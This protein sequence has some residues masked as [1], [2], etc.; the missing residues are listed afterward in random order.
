MTAPLLSVEGLHVR[1][2]IGAGMFAKGRTLRAVSDVS[3]TM[4][5]GECLGIVGESGCGKS[6]LARAI[7]GFV[8]PAQGRVLWRGR[9]V[10]ELDAAGLREFRR[11]V[12]PVFQ[13]PLGSLNPRMTVGD[14]IAEPLETLRPDIAPARRRPLAI[15]W[16]EKLGL[17]ADMADRYPSEFSGGQ[18]Q[19]IAIARAMIAE[20]DLL[21]CDEAVSALDVSVKAQI[22]N[23]LID[24]QRET[25]I[26][27]LFISH[28]LAI[29]RQIATHVMVM[30]LG[31]LMED[32]PAPALFGR[33]YHPYTQALL[34]AV[35]VP[36]PDIEQTR[37]H[38]L[39]KDDVPSP[40]DPPS[41]CVFRTRCPVAKPNCILDVPAVT[42]ADDARRVAC[43]YSGIRLEEVG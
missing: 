28:D 4:D 16:L 43:H 9:D 1:F 31:C 2:Q 13:N 25:G 21:I 33:Q 5:G 35:P 17:T 11:S 23:L 18:A 36:D 42:E 34:S 3:L 12:Q 10:G 20:P 27:I 14:I 22:V 8:K 24:L 40:L 30:Y 6:T 29:V 39:L 19:R 26:S 37:R 38:L 15:D 32:A 41:G 7:L